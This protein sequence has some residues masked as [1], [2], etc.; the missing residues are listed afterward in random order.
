MGSTVVKRG[1][2][3]KTGACVF[4]LKA[5]RTNWFQT[6]GLIDLFVAELVVSKKFKYTLHNMSTSC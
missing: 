4:F 3:L 1:L 6:V 2:Y 5:K